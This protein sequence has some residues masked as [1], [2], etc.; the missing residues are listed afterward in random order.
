MTI[1]ASASE[2][3]TGKAGTTVQVLGMDPY[4]NTKFLQAHNMLEAL[5]AGTPIIAMYGGRA[6]PPNFGNPG[7]GMESNE[8]DLFEKNEPEWFKY[9]SSLGTLSPTEMAIIGCAFRESVDESGFDDNEIVLDEDTRKL[10]VLTDY[11]YREGHRVVTVWG[12]YHSY[13]QRPIKEVEEIDYVE[14]IDF[15]MP[16]VETYKRL[17]RTM[18]G[19]LPIYPYWSHVRRL[20]IALSI[21]DQYRKDREERVYLIG[22]M[23][24]SSWRTVF[25]VGRGD[26]RFPPFGYQITPEDWYHMFDIMIEK[27]IEVLDEDVL[28]T[29]FNGKSKTKILAYDSSGRTK[30]EER[31]K[32]LDLSGKI[33]F[34]KEQQERRLERENST[35]SVPEISTDDGELAGSED[36]TGLRS[37]VE[38]LQAEDEEYAK[39][40]E[41]EFGSE[42]YKH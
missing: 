7:G 14:W 22:R 18:G 28:L 34:A 39:S 20:A 26:D 42:W 23:L 15:S 25:R 29:E 35:T 16:M 13:H 4:S 12:K 40:L 27:G 19:E 3:I 41:K 17:R 8:L 10:I 31:K 24:H 32:N 6:K 1:D 33:S 11:H 21:I 5:I 9:Y 38:I 36:Y 37:S 2:N 30:T